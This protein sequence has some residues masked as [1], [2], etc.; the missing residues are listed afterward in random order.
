[1]QA[2]ATNTV[3]RNAR[4]SNIFPMS[5]APGADLGTVTYFDKRLVKYGGKRLQEPERC[6]NRV[7]QVERGA[8]SVSGETLPEECCEESD[9]SEHSSREASKLISCSLA[10]AG[11]FHD[12]QDNE[13]S[14]D[15]LG[16]R[17]SL[18]GG[19]LVVGF[20]GGARDTVFWMMQH[21]AWQE[22]QDPFF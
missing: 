14:T 13:G 21:D 19:R 9:V 15:S 3:R 17:T 22:G 7:R 6:V 11:D 5:S 16:L 18:G 10:V 8:T 1:M 20:G 4:D 12:R 2:S